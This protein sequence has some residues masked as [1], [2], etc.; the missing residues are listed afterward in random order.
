MKLKVVALLMAVGSVVAYAQRAPRISPDAIPIEEEP[1]HEIRLTNEFVRV[2][3]ATLPPGYVTKDHIHEADS[4]SVQV[5]NGRAGEEGRRIGSARFS[6]GGYSHVVPNN[7]P[8]IVR[9]IVVEPI[10]ADN[11]GA[12]AAAL[13]GH[14]LEDENERVRIYRVR[15]DAGAALEDHSH[16]SGWTEVTVFGPDET[17]SF[18]WTGGGQNR[19]LRAPD[20]EPLEIVEIEPR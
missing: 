7:N 12:A 15:L 19:P 17:G 4:V 14:T 6:P 3:D 11:P 5:A 8:E 1:Q 13:P 18:A 16:G 20:D 10:R 2:I 9:Y